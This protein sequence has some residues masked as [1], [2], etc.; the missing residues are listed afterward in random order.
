MQVNLSES[1]H[2]CFHL[3]IWKWKEM[4]ALNDN[5]AFINSFTVSDSITKFAL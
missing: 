5:V 4:I 2:F 3:N 1:I